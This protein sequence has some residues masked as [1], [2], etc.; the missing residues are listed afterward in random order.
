MCLCWVFGFGVEH[1]MTRAHTTVPLRRV[2]VETLIV[3][4]ILQI[5]TATALVVFNVLSPSAQ[6]DAWTA[7]QIE[8]ADLARHLA[9][10][11]DVEK[12]VVL[13]T[14]LVRMY[15]LKYLKVVVKPWDYPK[16]YASLDKSNEYYQG[17]VRELRSRSALD[18]LKPSAELKASASC[19][20]S[21]QGQT[22]RTGHDRSRTGCPELN[23]GEN[24]DYGMRTGR[25]IVMHLLVDEGVPSLGHR[26]NILNPSYRT[27]G[28]GHAPHRRYGKMTVQQF[29]R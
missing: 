19:F 11:S 23:T 20:A 5:L 28:V 4:K 27:I 24:C 1:E 2:D 25:D 13:H 10:W 9:G 17:L 15:P 14:N 7:Q 8:S 12:D 22:S 26:E 18:P 21:A 3:M 29:S 6:T 16:R